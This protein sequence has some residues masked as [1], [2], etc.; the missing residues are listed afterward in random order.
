VK[1]IKIHTY[2]LALALCLLPPAYTA[3]AQS[4]D[5]LTPQEVELVQEAQILDKRIDVFIKAMDRRMMVLTGAQ[6]SNAKQFKKD[7]ET[8]GELPQGSRA[9][10]I[11]DISG[12]LEEAIT[13]IDDVSMHD[14]KNP[15][16]SKAL[17]KLSAAAKQLA[18]QLA[19]MRAQAKSEAEL[20]GIEQVLQS[21]ESIM[22]A[23]KKLPAVSETE[24]NKRK[25]AKEKP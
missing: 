1:R 6:P 12:I 3:T 4:R 11:G 22:D 25:K 8:W 19:P 13:N 17:R 18:D 7:S 23:E 9:Q 16:L 15:L 20:S 21:A 10:L 14:E 24:K 2:C 5:H